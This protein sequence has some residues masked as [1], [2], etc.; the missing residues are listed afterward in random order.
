M[1]FSVDM[2]LSATFLVIFYGGNFSVV[3]GT[4][5][6]IS[7]C[8]QCRLGFTSTAAVTITLCKW[9]SN[10]WKSEELSCVNKH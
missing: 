6:L 4:A 10:S 8:D 3:R 7:C 5:L 2:V 1:K 9:N